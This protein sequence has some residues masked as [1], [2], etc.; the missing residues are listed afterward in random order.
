MAP[1]RD[2]AR[3]HGRRSSLL[4]ATW[5]TVPPVEVSRSI[6]A[7]LKR[8][9]GIDSQSDVDPVGRPAIRFSV[10]DRKGRVRN[11]MR[12]GAVSI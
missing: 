4:A 2:Q 1:I 7:M 9:Q 3:W 11:V 8:V 12:L 6:L 5:E 10:K